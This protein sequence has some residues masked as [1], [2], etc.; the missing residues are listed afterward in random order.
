MKKDVTCSSE[1]FL[2]FYGLYGII[3]QKTE[4]FKWQALWNTV[5]HWLPQEARNFLSDILS[6][7][8]S[9]K[10]FTC[11]VIVRPQMEVS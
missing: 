1:I 5:N 11:R 10:T 7:I 9:R 8:F 6:T 3:S 4:L 2:T